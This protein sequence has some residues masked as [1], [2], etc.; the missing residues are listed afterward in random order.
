[1]D[2]LIRL[3]KYLS[4]NLSCTRRDADTYIESGRVKVNGVKPIFGMKI[5]PN[6][7]KVYFDGRLIE[8]VEEKIFILF[9]KPEGISCSTEINI[10]DN[11]TKYVRY[12]DRLFS[13]FRLSRE[14]EG[15]ILLTNSG[16]V[17]HEFAPYINNIPKEYIISF[18]RAVP[19]E[20]LNEVIAK[21]IKLGI[22][23]SSFT[24]KKINEYTLLLSSNSEIAESVCEVC[25]RQDFINVA[26]RRETLLG[27]NIKS[28]T[29]G[30]WRF[31]T[32]QEVDSLTNYIRSND[33][34]NERAVKPVAK[35]EDKITT[36]QSELKRNK[37]LKLAEAAQNPKSKTLRSGRKRS[38]KNANSKAAL[39]TPSKKSKSESTKSARTEAKKT[40]M[41]FEDAINNKNII[42]SA[43]KMKNDRKGG[44]GNSESK[45]S[46][47]SN[48]RR[49]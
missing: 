10:K 5:D 34:G 2:N 29:P 24:L 30:E 47:S 48:R 45:K 46:T 26:C 19:A 42:D 3:N 7:D 36:W 35:T 9:N 14:N 20:K 44:K 17:A 4:D 39:L 49:R 38:E 28:L 18:N 6:S 13:I 21:V 1:M 37:E 41:R 25:R 31:L 15:L 16:E 22:P 43:R 33:P 32:P 11:I 27:M 40:G 12:Q 8:N 23:A